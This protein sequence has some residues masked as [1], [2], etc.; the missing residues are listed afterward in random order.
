LSAEEAFALGRRLE[1]GARDLAW[2]E[3]LIKGGAGGGT[4][5]LIGLLVWNARD[6]E[7][8]L[9]LLLIAASLLL[10]GLGLCGSLV[11]LVRARSRRRRLLF[12]GAFALASAGLFRQSGQFGVLEWLAISGAVFLLIGGC[13]ALFL[14]FRAWRKL[15]PVLTR[16]QADLAYGEVLCFQTEAPDPKTADQDADGESTIEILPTSC[17]AYRVNAE[18]IGGLLVLEPHWA[19]AAPAHV[20]EV[21]WLDEPGAPMPPCDW[22]RT[23]RSMAPEEVG[24]LC[25]L[26]RRVLRNSAL[27]APCVVLLAAAAIR[28]VEAILR[29]GHH[30]RLTEIGW[31]LACLYGA[32][33]FLLRYRLYL[34]LREDAEL[35]RLMVVR[36]QGE[37]EFVVVE[38][39][40]RAGLLWTVDRQP[41]TWRRL[42]R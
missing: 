39:L 32:V 25:G 15:A 16:A 27:E 41:A 23:Q 14:R 11:E 5:A 1:A 42:S 17:L 7:S 38:L 31:L 21:P 8:L 40:P 9:L 29:G 6:V 18:V 13:S 12:L 35:A 3:K 26:A 37:E 34:R 28:I 24:E 22:V 20:S 4:L 19:A 2:N 33:V 30:P 36:P 10:V